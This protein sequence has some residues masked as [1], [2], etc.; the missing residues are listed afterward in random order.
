[1]IQKNTI[2][3]FLSLRSYAV[4]GVSRN[5]KK[6]GNIIYRM[7]KLRDCRVYAVNPHAEEVEGDRCYPRLKA[8]PEKVEGVVIVVPPK[9]TESIVKE[10]AAEGIRRVW[11]QQGSESKSAI[12]YCE[13]YGLDAIHGHCLLMF[14]E[15]VISVHRFHRWGMELFHKL[16]A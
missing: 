7:L 1:M 10:I 15:P 9:Q 6:F 2:D 4:V 3:D 12:E 8:L 11:M 5:G 13:Q 16:P 14:A